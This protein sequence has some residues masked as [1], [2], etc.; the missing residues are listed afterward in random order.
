MNFQFKLIINL[1]QDVSLSLSKTLLT[2][3]PVFRQAQ[4]KN[5]AQCDK[6][7]ITGYEK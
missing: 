5:V 1:N 7:L 6:L 4:Y 3:T 2:N